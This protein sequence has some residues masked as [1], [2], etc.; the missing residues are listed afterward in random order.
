[1]KDLTHRGT[2]EIETRRLLLRRFNMGDANE[3]FREW[4]NYDNVVKYLTWQKHSTISETKTCL[5]DIIGGYSRPDTYVWGIEH[6]TEGFLIGSISAEIIERAKTAELGFCLGERFWNQGYATEALRAVSDY[7]FLDVN[8]NRLE[9]Y[10]SVRNPA[11]GKVL[12]KAGFA[13]EGHMKQKYITGD[14]IYQDSDFYGLV[15]DDFNS[16]YEP[17]IKNFL[18]PGEMELTAHNLGLKCAGYYPKETKKDRLP[19]YRFDITDK[20]SGTVFGE[21][22]LYLGFDEALY[23]SGHIGC[24]VNEQYR[25]VGVAAAACK[26]ILNLAKMHEFQKMFVTADHADKASRRVCEKIGARLVRIA[27]L[28]PRHELYAKGGLFECVYELDAGL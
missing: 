7:M 17:G 21:I 11:S 9:A 18:D 4:A 23:Y 10:H 2:R 8:I 3:I 19:G 20:S 22:S 27:E 12:Q 5:L 6:K 15:K 24:F 1:M 13:K 25:N 28:P 14:K 16:R 26:I